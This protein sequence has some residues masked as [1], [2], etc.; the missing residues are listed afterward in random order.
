ML[1]ALGEFEI[2]GVKTLLG[3]HRALLGHPC[4]VAGETCHGIVESEELAPSCGASPRRA[5]P[6]PPPR[7]AR[8]PERETVAEVDGRRLSVRCSC[9]SRRSASSP[10]G[11]A[12]ERAAQARRR[13]LGRRGQPDAGHGAGVKVADGDEVEAGQVLCIVEAMKMENEVDAHRAGAVDRALGGGR[14]AG[15]DRPGDLPDRGRRL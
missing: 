12:N 13:R 3:F 7:T 14:P 4:F 1:R 6:Q 9:P 15:H 5:Q 8:R 11:G 10:G 2:G